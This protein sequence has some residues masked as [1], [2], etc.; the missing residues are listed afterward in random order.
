MKEKS[1][2]QPDAL[3]RW[4]ES[5]GDPSRMRMLRL[6][7]RHELGVAEL[8]D[9]LRL[10]QSTISRHLKTLNEQNWLRSRRVGTAH[11][12]SM[13]V[14]ELTDAQRRLW[15]LAREQINNWT[16]IS[17]DEFRLQRL[18]H[19]RSAGARKFFTGA[20]GEWDATREELYGSA[21]IESALL[22]L[23]PPE[24]VV[25]DLGC[26]TGQ[27]IERLAGHVARVIGIDNTPAMLQAARDR[28]ARLSNVEIKEGELD[29]LPFKDS[30]ID[31]TLTVLAMSYVPEPLACIHEM[32]RVLKAGGRAIIVDVTAHDR[33]DFRREMGQ[34]RLGF[35]AKE[36][37][38][39]LN[40]SGFRSTKYTP[41]PPEPSAKGPAL[42]LASGTK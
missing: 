28:T 11:F 26:G 12:S 21:F 31:I 5:L 8:S 13:F 25:A 36:I 18:L 1:S 4:M 6:L 34:S 19:Q 35:N 22:A 14:D 10:P 33:E 37:E 9:V 32:S 7:E 24:Y 20:A 3:I 39:M 41:L 2:Q 38:G 23:I 29:A 42:F 27:M 40:Q 15:H 16:T 17:Q 30:S